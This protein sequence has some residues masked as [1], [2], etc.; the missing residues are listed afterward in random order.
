MSDD[1]VVGVDESPSGRA[2]LVWAA[3][4]A[5]QTGARLRAIHVLGGAE[6]R[7][8]YASPVVTS[9]VIP[10]E[11]VPDPARTRD[12]RELFAGLDPEPS[13]TLQFAQGHPGQVMVDESNGAAMLVLGTR[14]HRGFGRLVNGSV[15]HFCISRASCPVIGVPTPTARAGAVRPGRR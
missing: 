15:S 8:L 11:D 2:A 12:V 1:I 10:D 14:E 7:E 13:W 3:Q 5:R 6:A 4:R 9:R